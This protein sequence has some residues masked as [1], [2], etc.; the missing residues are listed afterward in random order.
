MHGERGRVVLTATVTSPNDDTD[1]VV[2]ASF[3]GTTHMP[4][5]NESPVHAVALAPAILPEAVAGLP[6]GVVAGRVNVLSRQFQ[7]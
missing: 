4:I 6:P 7:G 1:A 3:L 5:T 2:A